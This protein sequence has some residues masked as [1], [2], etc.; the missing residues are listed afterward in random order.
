MV[1]VLRGNFCRFPLLHQNPSHCH[2]QAL[3]MLDRAE[4]E[5]R[6]ESTEGREPAPEDCGEEQEKGPSSPEP[7]PKG[8]GVASWAN[9]SENLWW[10]GADLPTGVLTGPELS[11]GLTDSVWGLGNHLLLALSWQLT[12]ALS[13]EGLRLQVPIGCPRG[14]FSAPRSLPPPTNQLCRPSSPP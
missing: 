3:M 9:S 12:W 10:C 14:L 1:V 13:V 6:Q 5:D 4:A 7:L 2:P 8:A 11:Y